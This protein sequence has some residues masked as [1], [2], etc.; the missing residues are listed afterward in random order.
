MAKQFYLW[1]KIYEVI[2]PQWRNDFQREQI[3]RTHLALHTYSRFVPCSPVVVSEYFRTRLY[4][5]SVLLSLKKTIKFSQ[6][7]N[8]NDFPMN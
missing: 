2:A 4:G 8:K 6:K 5:E 3:E 7:L 1:R